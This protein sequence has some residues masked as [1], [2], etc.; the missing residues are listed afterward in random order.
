MAFEYGESYYGLRTWGSSAG[1]V[2]DA[3]ASLTA[4]SSIG[5]VNWEVAIGSGTVTITVTSA[6]TCSGEQVI[7]E[8]SDRYTYG[9][10]LWGRNVFAG[11]A[12][13]QT[14]VTA[15]SSVTSACERIRLSGALVAGA[16][17]VAAIGGFTA[18][19]SATAT[20]TSA[21]TCSGQVV[22]ERSGA[23]TS[24]SSITANSTC[25]FNF[26]I[27]IAVTSA[28]TCSAEDFFLESSDLYAYGSGLYGTQVFDQADLQ[29][30][31]TATSS[32]ACSAERIH[33]GVAT[34]DGTASI[35]V[36]ARRIADGSVL[37]NGTSVTTA[38][39]NGNGSRVRTSGAPLTSTA[40]VATASTIVRVRESSANPSATSALTAYAVT[41]VVGDASLT[42]T[43]TI[44]AICNRVRFG[45]GTPTAN[46]TIQALGFATRGGIASLTGVTTIVAD[47]ERIQQ[48]YATIQPEAVVTATCN[49]VQSTSGALS[50]TSGT[51]TIGREKWELI[52]N[53]TNTWTQIAA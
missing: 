21:T 5:A 6:T 36:L 11:D 31:V 29:T 52:V 12:N 13:L 3:S 7:L 23:I 34:L 9:S 27:P 24:A 4:T 18:N 26:T 19:V 32:V 51:A 35:S 48:P 1:E 15:T 43:A 49:R 47:S 41:V 28:T 50:A 20:S 45:S 25:T 16:S 53:N 38:T 37:L 33:L 39:S 46:A 30:I 40:T 8:E 14:V 2:K 10:G 42:G 44:A 17:G 22:G